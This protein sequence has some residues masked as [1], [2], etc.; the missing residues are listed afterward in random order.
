MIGLLLLAAPAWWLTGCVAD[1]REASHRSSCK[2]WL[3]QYGLAMHNYHD[4][5]GSFPPAFVLGPDGQTVPNT[6]A[7]FDHFA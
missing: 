1:A 6:W 3:K 5:Y 2:C 4:T 7:S